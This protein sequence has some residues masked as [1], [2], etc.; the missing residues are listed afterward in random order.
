[1]SRKSL[2]SRRSDE[3]QL[4]KWGGHNQSWNRQPERILSDILMTA[5]NK[6]VRKEE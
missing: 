2:H 5:Q 3:T 1:M 4:Q 6:Y